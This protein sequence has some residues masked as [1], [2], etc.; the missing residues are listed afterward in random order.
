LF[1]SPYEFVLKVFSRNLKTENKNLFSISV[2]V[3][4]VPANIARQRA[5][6][7]REARGRAPRFFRSCAQTARAQS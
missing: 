7:T 2:A 4:V 5:R 6:A 3:A 1:F